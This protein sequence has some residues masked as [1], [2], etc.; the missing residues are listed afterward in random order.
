MKSFFLSLPAHRQ[1]II[2]IVVAAILWSTGGVFIKLLPQDAFTILF[3]RSALAASLF[4]IVYG[5]RVLHMNRRAWFNSVFYCLLL[6]SFVV[7]TKLTTAA[8]AILLQ[9]TAPIY[10]LLA[11]PAL[12]KFKLEKVNVLTIIACIL[13]MGILLSG[14]ISVGNWTG[15]V[16]A[17]LSGVAL[18][19]LLLGQRL[20]APEYQVRSIF[21][22]NVLVAL[23]GLP[24]FLLSQMPTLPQAAMLGFLGIFQIGTGYLLFTYGLKRVLAIEGALL[25]MLEPIL[26]PV[27]VWMGYGEKPTP[28]AMLGGLFILAALTGRMIWLE[29]QRRQHLPE[30]RFQDT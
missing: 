10:V 8:N 25:A 28:A 2:A 18:A 21:W 26:N 1:G 13:G 7:S 23:V 22:G 6:I 12:F 17:L 29:W 20:N 3:Y 9:Y 11:E 15:N 30:K 16:I 24:F 5:K 19:A 4:G 14:D 27:W